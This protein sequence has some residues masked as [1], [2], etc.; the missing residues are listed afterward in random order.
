MLG[1]II[2]VTAIG[3]LVSMLFYYYIIPILQLAEKTRLI[4]TV[5]PDYRIFPKGGREV[6]YLTGIINDYADTFQ[7]LK[8][9]VDERIRAAQDEVDEERNRL[10]ALM[11]ELPNGV[12]VCNNDGLILLYNQ[13]AQNLLQTDEIQNGEQKPAGI[14]GL[15]RSV[16]GLLQR[17]P[18]IHAFELL[19]QTVN[20]E[21]T[22]STLGFMMTLGDGTCL[23]LNMALVLSHRS[24]EK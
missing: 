22:M 24:D 7:K 12:L 18:I 21:Q 9:E 15:G 10:A 23:R 19:Q 20:R 11:S 13:Q 8:N 1:S 5:N 16:F 14:I 3:G 2:L 17:E 4:A 6:V